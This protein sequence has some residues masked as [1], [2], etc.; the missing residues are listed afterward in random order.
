MNRIPGRPSTATWNDNLEKIGSRYRMVITS[1]TKYIMVRAKTFFEDGSKTRSTGISWSEP[2]GLERVFQL[3]L[4]MG[5]AEKPLRV[6]GVT[7]GSVGTNSLDGWTALALLLE[8]DLNREGIKWRGQDYETHMKEIRA[9][10]SPVRGSK[11]QGWVLTAPDH[12]RTRVRRLVTLRRLLTLADFD[13]PMKWFEDI[14][15]Y[16][17]H[18]SNRANNSRTLPT[19]A[20]IEDFIDHIENPAWRAVFG[21]CAAYGLRPHEPFTLIDWPDEDGFI[22]LDSKKSGSRGLTPRRPDW[23]DR[24]NLRDAVLPEHNPGADGKDLGK[25]TT[26]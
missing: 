13:I 16:S 14:K 4:E 2:K 6:L 24:W 11:L 21:F 1:Q 25:K 9:F 3:V 17:K 5:Y 23:V 7:E 8:A 26:Q 18:D 20:Q 10:K 15:K 22:Y 12:S 19:D